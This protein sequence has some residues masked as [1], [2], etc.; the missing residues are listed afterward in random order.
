MPGCACRG[1]QQ[2]AKIRCRHA[3]DCPIVG[4]NANHPKIGHGCHEKSGGASVEYGGYENFPA[5]GSCTS[6]IPPLE[7]RHRASGLGRF[8][9]PQ[10]KASAGLP[11]DERSPV[12]RSPSKNDPWLS[13]TQGQE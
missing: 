1:E 7:L 6:L 2:H 5:Y 12:P 8:L 4:H 10:L 13:H 11:Y 9:C 3:V